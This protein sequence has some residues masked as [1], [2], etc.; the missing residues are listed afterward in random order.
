MSRTFSAR[1]LAALCFSLASAWIPQSAAADEGDAPTAS[2]SSAPAAKKQPGKPAAK[3]PAKQAVTS[4]ASKGAATV[5]KKAGPVG[6]VAGVLGGGGSAGDKAKAIATQVGIKVATRV[7]SMVAGSTV[8]AAFGGLT[9]ILG[10]IGDAVQR[11]KCKLGCC[12][13]R[14]LKG[15]WACKYQNKASC[16]GHYSDYP[17][18]GD[19][20]CWWNEH[21]NRCEVGITCRDKTF[22]FF[23]LVGSIC[24]PC[25]KDP[26]SEP[27]WSKAQLKTGDLPAKFY[28]DP[29]DEYL[30]CAPKGAPGRCSTVKNKA[31]CE[32][33][34]A[35]FNGDKNCVWRGT[36]GSTG[37]CTE[38]AKCDNARERIE[39]AKTLGLT[40]SGGAWRRQGAPV[41]YSTDY[42]PLG[43]PDF[44]RAVEAAAAHAGP[45]QAAA[46]KAAPA[47]AAPAKAAPAKAAAKKK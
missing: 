44:V 28:V 37:T 4:V 42:K 46:A 47:K 10:L 3:A 18:H 32:Q 33:S 38:G 20:A 34:Y 39:A 19:H 31:G 36:T 24:P 27:Q 9:A 2:A 30:W 29:K 16:D 8:G 23:A 12:P 14:N 22:N 13:P 35:D 1:F 43:G 25:P 45:A 15:S 26:V 17:G 21:F 40:Y 41:S 11:D 6:K 7:V 5:L